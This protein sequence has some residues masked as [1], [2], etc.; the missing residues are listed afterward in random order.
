MFRAMS[1]LRKVGIRPVDHGVL[2][3]VRELAPHGIVAGLVAL[4]RFQR[5]FPPVRVVLEMVG[6][7][8]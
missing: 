8:A 4:V 7:T 1:R 5:A 2:V 6:G 3:A